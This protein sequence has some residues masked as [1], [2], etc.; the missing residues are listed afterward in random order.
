[1]RE[2]LLAIVLT[3]AIGLYSDIMDSIIGKQS[4]DVKEYDDKYPF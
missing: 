3:W 1:M 2:I 4:R